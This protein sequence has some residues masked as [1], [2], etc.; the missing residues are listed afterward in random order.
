MKNILK[1]AILFY[2]IN[3]CAQNQDLKLEIVNNEI[4]SRENFSFTKDN[5]GMD[6]KHSTTPYIIN[7][8]DSIP[9]NKINVK[10]TNSGKKPYL[11]YLTHNFTG[12][13]WKNSLSFEVSNDLNEIQQANELVLATE[14]IE[15]YFFRDYFNKKEQA[16]LKKE[17]FET[18]Y[19]D[20]VDIDKIKFNQKFN[21]I[22]IHPNESKYITLYQAL[23]FFRFESPA[24]YMYFLDNKK[25]YYFQVI[26]KNEA[27]SNKPFLSENQKKE[28]EENGYEIF[29]GVIKS[30][31]VPIK[32]VKM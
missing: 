29:D 24:Y 2:T 5:V 9:V 20:T 23:P 21:P 30:N 3:S 8:N 19:K 27:K 12:F 13:D 26:L 14:T 7:E 4:L 11:L 6:E 31:K 22:I 16:A 18:H 15:A 10:I 1:I 32:F 28:I 17:L 25:N